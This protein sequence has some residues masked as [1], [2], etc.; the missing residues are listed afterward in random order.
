MKY[1]LDVTVT[2]FLFSCLD[3]EVN[4]TRST[5]EKCVED[6]R[7]EAQNNLLSGGYNHSYDG[8]VKTNLK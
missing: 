7:R 3:D 2:I 4:G 5:H 8:N 6:F 1:V